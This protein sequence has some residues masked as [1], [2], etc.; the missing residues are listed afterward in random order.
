[1][2]NLNFKD[3]LHFKEFPPISTEEWE[4]VIK[5]D[6]KGKNYKD[7]LE[8]ES[9]EGVN[10]LP[11]YRKE[12]L[13]G[14]ARSPIPVRAS[15]SWNIIEPIEDVDLKTAN[16]LALHAL[17]NGASGLL[18]E[19]QE[20]RIS[21]QSDLEILLK[22]IKIEFITV[23]FGLHLST[24]KITK[25]L[26]AICDSRG[27]QKEKLNL[28]FS[29]DPFSTAIQSGK[30][31]TKNSI[32]N[33]LNNS[34]GVFS[35]AVSD[36][37]VYANSGASIVQQ[38]AFALAAGNELLGLNDKIANDLYFNFS[39]GPSYFP[40]LAK[41]R[42]FK[43][44][45][46]RVLQEYG[47]DNTST[48]IHGETPLWNKSKTDAH[49]NMLRSTT[50]AMAA[51]LGGCNSITVH[52]Y[53]KHF[54]EPSGFSSR[55]ARNIQLILQEESYLDRV[56][57]PGAGA[58]YIEVLTDKI[59]KESWKLFQ[60]IEAKGGFHECLKE[61]FIQNEI[62]K[63][64]EEKIS[65]YK[66]K[67]KVLVGVNKYQPDEIHNSNSKIQNFEFSDTP[68]IDIQKI[69]PLNIEAELQKEDA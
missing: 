7:V 29:F 40:E 27:I 14:L 69:E 4:E 59:V 34:H 61:E 18:F 25:W 32:T 49:N 24:P 20:K 51:A 45:W 23:K 64:R 37:S 43:L 26:A 50:E 56:A 2:N 47:F 41:F 66:E 52:P 67:K 16:K 1:M 48:A 13:Q 63:S 38:I 68:S 6:L 15:T 5:S 11:F 9:G 53:D 44:M 65:A 58:Y 8:W 22:D 12:H 39:S 35:F 19:L 46:D 21:S 57:D 60:E 3:N 55:I 17:E 31:L 62:T 30:L 33:M 36:A 10:A 42:A 28:Y 54:D